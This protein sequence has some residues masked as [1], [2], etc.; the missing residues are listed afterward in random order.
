M[1]L[2]RGGDEPAG[3]DDDDDFDFPNLDAVEGSKE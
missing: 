1:F 3:D 2:H